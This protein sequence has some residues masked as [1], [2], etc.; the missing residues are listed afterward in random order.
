MNISVGDFIYSIKRLCPETIFKGGKLKM[1]AQSI[2]D[3]G[4]LSIDDVESLYMT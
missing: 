4:K 3:F 2:N 1:I